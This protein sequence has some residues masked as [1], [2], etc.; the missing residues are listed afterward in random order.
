VL[1]QLNGGNEKLSACCIDKLRLLQVP[2][3][4]T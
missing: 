1:L 4:G 3:L 2:T